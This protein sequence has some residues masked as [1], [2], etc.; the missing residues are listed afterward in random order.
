MLTPSYK[1][2][3]EIPDGLKE[4]YTQKDGLFILDG[5]VPKNKMEEFRENNK[6]LAKEREELQTQ[7]LK[8]KDIDPLQYAD[9]VTKLRELENNR[10]V[11]AGE[12]K[13]LQVNLEQQ[14]ADLMKVEKEK[15]TA[16]QTGWN[17]EKIANQ[18]AMT[19][20]KH[21]L[22]AEGN[23]QYIQSDIQKISSIDPVTNQIVFLDEK[24]LKKKNEAGDGDL[25]LDEYLTKIYIPKSNL[26]QKSEGG[27][28]L[29]GVDIPM[30]AQGQV[31]V[32]SISGRDIPGD[33]ISDL[34]TGKVTAI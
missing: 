13:V 7:L 27:G 23:M 9:A 12:W 5:F 17:A 30:I 32:D 29:G 14:H 31:S 8:F 6:A 25:T 22:P 4:H 33:M 28:G 2:A 10:L 34:A 11:D 24:G 3:E 16:I 1:T 18:T 20:L 19:V 26:F 21:A 15:S